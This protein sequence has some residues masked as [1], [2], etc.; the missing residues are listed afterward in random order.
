MRGE[1]HPWRRTSAPSID[2]AAVVDALFDHV[3][4]LRC[5]VDSDGHIVRL[6][7]D[8][9]GITGVDAS[10]AV[11]Q[12][13]HDLLPAAHRRGG[14]ADVTR[15]L[16]SGAHE[17]FECEHRSAS[18]RTLLLR[19]SAHPLNGVTLLVAHDLTTALEADERSRQQLEARAR[20]EHF[21][22]TVVDAQ[23][24]LIVRVDAEH[25]ITFVNDAYC[26]TFGATRQQL[27]GHPFTPLVH[28]DD[29]P[30]T[31]AARARL[32]EPPHRCTLEQ[33]AWT[34]DGWRWI[35]WDDVAFADAAG[36]I[37]EIQSVGRDITDL[38]AT[39]SQARDQV[40]REREVTAL[41]DVA[42]WDF[43]Y[44]TQR[45]SWSD[46]V[47]ALFDTDPTSFIPTYEGFVNLVHPLDREH[48]TQANEIAVRERAPLDIEHR[49]IT[50]RGRLRWVAQRATVSVGADGQPDHAVGIIQDISRRKLYDP[51][52]GLATLQLLHDHLETA[53]DAA[54]AQG[55]VVAL[56]SIDL[57]R[58][59]DVN[60]RY[61]RSTGND[62][63]VHVARRLDGTLRRHDLAVRVAGDE[64]VVLLTMLRSA[65]EA[66]RAGARLAE[67]LQRP[68][69]LDDAA[70]EISAS[71]GVAIHPLDDTPADTLRR[72]ADQA[73]Q[74]AKLRSSERLVVYD[75]ATERARRARVERRARIA[76]A[77]QRDEMVLHFQPTI[78]LRSGALSGAEA[79]VRWQHPSEGLLPPG[80]FLPDILDSDLELTLDRWVMTRALRQWGAW[81]RAGVVP[82]D[83]SVG[84]NVS[85]RSLL[86]P[87]F[88]DEL[89]DHLERH[90]DAPASA[91]QLEVLESSALSDLDAARSVLARCRSLGVTVALDDFGTG[92][93][94]LSHF[95]VLPT[96]VVKVDRAFVQGMLDDPDD[97]GIVTT[98]VA[99]GQAFNRTV[100]AEGVETL[101]Q[102]A[103]LQALGCHQIQGYML[104]RPQ[105][106]EAF[107]AWVADWRSARIRD[108]LALHELVPADQLGLLAA[109]RSHEGWAQQVLGFVAS[110]GTSAL[111]ILD[112]R[113]C[114]FAS[115]YFGSGSAR[116]GDDA[117]YLALEGEH[118][119]LHDLARSL[120]EQV[121]C[122]AAPVETDVE[123]FTARHRRLLVRL[124]RLRSTLASAREGLVSSGPMSAATPQDEPRR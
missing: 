109:A 89:R 58:F 94:S 32:H 27:L 70:I 88:L 34:V 106:P 75:Q 28:D 20:S 47:H 91:L 92:H 73:M 120:V 98:V 37:V 52:T 29:P 42:R 87:R 122:G 124:G 123:A 119:E 102:A 121:Q 100:C 63:L 16:T 41:A 113:H 105:P 9:H 82:A 54:R 64:F 85:A 39:Q 74:A 108:E 40:L 115:W 45:L 95:R 11:G 50:A 26:R 3:P 67:E 118:A 59:A 93:S 49:I 61:G 13:L 17:R 33:R 57:D 99:L 4:G 24:E 69:A 66:R 76:Q 10:A 19:W 83:A 36:A 60:E 15:A 72:Q 43:D 65:G 25:R 38:K 68:F 112:G 48:V 8:W 56:C 81:R 80:R 23:S 116:F 110:A 101:E 7:A 97:L 46:A 77:L 86:H 103:S 53:L 44:R 31:M 18:G 96:D 30:N 71:I 35:A 62:L 117:T 84:V 78:D 21:F 111:P 12:R 79:L 6:S 14:S 107:V 104:A 22:Q 51:L 5:L 90:P 114:A 55:T 2:D 1:T